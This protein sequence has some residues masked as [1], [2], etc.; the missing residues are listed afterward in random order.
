MASASDGEGAGERR[1]GEVS[2]GQEGD[3]V[4]TAGGGA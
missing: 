4:S 3:A 1:H 2:S